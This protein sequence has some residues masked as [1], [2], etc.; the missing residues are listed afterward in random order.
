[1][2]LWVFATLYCERVTYVCVKI[3]HDFGSFARQLNPCVAVCCSVLK[4]HGW[5]RSQL[6]ELCVCA[7]NRCIDSVLIY[8]SIHVN[9]E[10]TERYTLCAG[11]RY[12]YIWWI[13]TST[14]INTYDEYIY[15]YWYLQRSIH[16]M[17]TYINRYGVATISR[18]LKTIGL[19][20]KRAL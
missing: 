14:D 6:R 2:F 5:D 15:I 16:M 19:V 1:V 8:A 11:C 20:C 4:T 12:H 13:H 3:R 18:L 9:V 7:A 17:D 10:K